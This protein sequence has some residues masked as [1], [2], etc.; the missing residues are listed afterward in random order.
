MAAAIVAL[1]SGLFF[2]V[3]L[4]ISGM[5]NPQKVKAFLDVFGQWDPS[6]A[7]VMGGAVGLNLLLFDF[8][9]RRRPLLASDHLLPSKKDIDGRLVVGSAIFGIGWGLNGICPGPGL[10]N[11][12]S[13]SPSAIL[14]VLSMIF[15]VVLFKF[16][17]NSAKYF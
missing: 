16:I 4:I 14:F 5:T 2:S 10:V 1:I 8:I 17:F 3:G 13:G 9:K 6:L 7:F 11:M 12:V 15:G